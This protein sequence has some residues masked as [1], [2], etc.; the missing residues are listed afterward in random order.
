VPV[1]SLRSEPLEN[2]PPCPLPL[3]HALFSH[4]VK[5]LEK[6]FFSPMTEEPLEKVL[7]SPL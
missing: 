5:T 1:S 6:E 2:V 7:V 3:E 4:T